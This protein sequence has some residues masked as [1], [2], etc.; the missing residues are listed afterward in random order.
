ML[1]SVFRVLGRAVSE[2]RLGERLVLARGIAGAVGLIVVVAIAPVASSTEHGTDPTHNG[3]NQQLASITSSQSESPNRVHSPQSAAKTAQRL[4]TTSILAFDVPP[5]NSLIGATTES[6]TDDTNIA[7]PAAIL[8]P[9]CQ[10]ITKDEGRLRRVMGWSP[11][12]LAKAQSMTRLSPAELCALPSAARDQLSALIKAA[13]SAEANGMIEYLRSRHLDRSGKVPVDALYKAV[14]QHEALLKRHAQ[15]QERSRSPVAGISPSAWV[16]LGPTNTYSGRVRALHIDPRNSAIMVVGTASGGI[17]RTAD[18]GASWLPNDSFSPAFSITGLRTDPSNPDTI[19]AS[20]GELFPAAGLWRSADNGVIWQSMPSIV[21]GQLIPGQSAGNDAYVASLSDVAV[22]PASS[23]IIVSS[24]YHGVFVTRDSGV[25]WRQ[26]ASHAVDSADPPTTYFVSFDPKD[27]R[28]VFAGTDRGTVIIGTGIGTASEQ[29][30]EQVIA[31]QPVRTLV[32]A[33]AWSKDG[34][35]AW[36]TS[37]ESDGTVYRSTDGGITFARLS[38][39]GY[40]F[41]QC[42]YNN[43]LWVDPTNSN[44]IVLGGLPL[45]RSV[46]GGVTWEDINFGL[47]NSF[48]HVDHH[49][50]LADPGYN[51]TTN[52]TV[53]F[54]NDGGVYRTTDITA[55]SWE[56]GNTP[57]NALIWENFGKGINATQFYAFDA[58]SNAGAILGGTQDNG[59]FLFQSGTDWTDLF[60]GDGGYAGVPNAGTPLYFGQQELRILRQPYSATDSSAF[61]I[62]KG[63]ADAGYWPLFTL[64]GITGT[65][66]ET[67]ICGVAGQGANSLFLA[68]LLLDPNNDRRMYAG[69]ESLWVSNDVSTGVPVW[70]AIKGPLPALVTRQFISAIAV[71]P[72][73]ANSVWVG[74]TNGVVYRTLNALATAPDWILVTSV[75]PDMT[76]RQ[77][78]SIYISPSSPQR[79]T[80]TLSGYW[81]GSSATN[82]FR[83]IDAGATWSNIS[84]NLP[85]SVPYSVVEHPTNPNFL[86]VGTDTGIYATTDGITWSAGN[87]GPAL[88]PVHMLKWYDNSTLLAATHGRGVWRATDGSS[89]P[90]PPAKVIATPNGD[91]QVAVS[92]SAPLF[93]RDSPITGYTVTSNPSGGVDNNAGT[94]ALIHTITGLSNGTAYTFT[95]K[96]RNATGESVASAPAVGALSIN[97]AAGWNLAGNSVNAPLD[98]ATTFTNSTNVT[99]IWKWLPNTNRWAFY[100]PNESDGGQAYASS[101]GY[102]FLS[103]INAGE[104]FWVDAKAPSTVLLPV[105]TAVTGTSFQGLSSGWHLIS[106]GDT[107]TTDAFNTDVAVTTLWTWDNAQSKWYFYAPSLRTQGGSALSDYI[108][109]NG[110]LDF[111][112]AGKTLGPGV[113]FWV[114][115]P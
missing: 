24:G 92:F 89:V 18:A 30:Q 9:Q 59:T 3:L 113:G 63:I 73:D 26:V 91:A 97:L 99:S 96:A 62:C 100:S 40:C 102:E 23:Q 71:A 104:G 86:Y 51:G 5:S 6:A 33:M 39:P 72:G 17:W 65:Y 1:F 12:T 90:G 67:P 87:D 95:V 64:D 60:M 106:T 58:N 93:G 81:D 16:A 34:T 44:R 11:K 37:S 76:Y 47:N 10:D 4:K 49:A 66:I 105:G 98:V 107:K 74:Y 21:P 115:K 88:V 80:I 78:T 69:G 50:A 29:W 15:Q 32:T 75:L 27:A 36:I 7:Q 38:T 110:Y 85:I 41:G 54:G 103:T 61:F 56:N 22:S 14:Q 84:G 46:D 55:P 77:V 68:P 114:N 52:K 42:W 2:V 8:N 108:K 25:T 45:R 109:T 94:T 79:V 82:V 43:S 101:K 70:R 31:I 19:Y 48:N 112:S 53:Y 20:T 83:T 57:A 35:S 13:R 111:T 28:K